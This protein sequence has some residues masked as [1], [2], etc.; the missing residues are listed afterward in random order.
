MRS[1]TTMQPARLWIRRELMRFRAS[2]RAGSRASKAT[3]AMWWACRWRGCM[4]CCVRKER[5]R[6]RVTRG[7]IQR[8][9]NKSSRRRRGELR[10]LF[11]FFVFFLWFF[12][13]FHGGF[14]VTDAF[15]QTLAQRGK[16]AGAEDQ[17]NDR[18]D[19]YQM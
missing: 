17:K 6:L 15:A 10:L 5:Y 2:P 13:L 9:M 16:L 14:E 3:T 7:D 18:Y 4:R 1:A 19:Q 11:L 12:P 8:R